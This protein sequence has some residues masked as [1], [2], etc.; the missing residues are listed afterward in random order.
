MVL[1]QDN[2]GQWNWVQNQ[3]QGDATGA[4]SHFNDQNTQVMSR[5]IQ[6]FVMVNNYKIYQQMNWIYWQVPMELKAFKLT[7]DR[8]LHNGSK[9]ASN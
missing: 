7:E 1:K 2:T 5:V 3:V 4:A 9:N 6:K 8:G